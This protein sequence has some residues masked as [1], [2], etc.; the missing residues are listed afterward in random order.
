MRRGVL[1]VV[2]PHVVE[3]EELRLGTEV[4]GVGQSG[5]H[6]VV[7]GLLR[8]VARI[9]RVGLERDRVVH[10]AVDVQRLVGAERVDDGRVRVGHEDHVRLLDL[11][12]AADRRAVE[13]E[14]LVEGIGAELVQ[15][16]REVLHQSW[17]VTEAEVDDLDSLVL[18]QG[19]YLVGCAFLHG[20]S[21]E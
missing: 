15:R 4:R 1:V 3:D 18:G 21:F 19:Q 14:T 16:R 9:T 12:E 17:Q 8:D 5:R 2:E 20:S 11:L 13:A 6:E 7:L 10:E